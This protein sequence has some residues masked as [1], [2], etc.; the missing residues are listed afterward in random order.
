[1][2]LNNEQEN[3]LL[4]AVEEIYRSIAD[5]FLNNPGLLPVPP[6]RPSSVIFI[7]A[8]KLPANKMTIKIK[9]TTCSSNCH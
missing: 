2:S 3:G 5:G 8:N 6:K 4:R 9:R 7:C 1:M